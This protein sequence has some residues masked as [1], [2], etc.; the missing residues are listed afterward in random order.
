MPPVSIY[1]SSTGYLYS[2][3]L[4]LNTTPSGQTL[5]MRGL[6][7]VENFILLTPWYPDP[8]RLRSLN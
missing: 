5:L 8:Y 1:D 6:F 7:C 3:I 4:G 2:N